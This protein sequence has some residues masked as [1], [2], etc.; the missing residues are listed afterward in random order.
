MA[1]TTACGTIIDLIPVAERVHA[2]G[3][4]LFVDA[5]QFAPHGPL[6]V[7][8]F[9][10]DLL[11]CSGYKI[12]GPH[13]G[14]MWGKKEVLDSLPAFREYFIQD[15]A[16]DKYEVGT[17]SFE[18]IAGMN[19][20][21]GYVE[22]LGRRSRHL[23]LAPEESVGRRGDM[24]R[25][26]QVIRHYERTLSDRLLGRIRELPF[27]EVFGLVEPEHA[28]LRTPT[29]CF[30]VKG[31]E[32]AKVTQSLAQEGIFVRDGHLYCPRLFRALG[33][34]EETGAVR[35]SLVHYNSVEEMDRFVDALQ[36]LSR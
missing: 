11:V 16:P 21:I 9:G 4:Y 34:S 18:G 35:A 27:I 15:R 10:C 13:I 36:G 8:F 25:G 14:F 1:S 20:A 3:G 17:Q 5:V 19:A 28:A 32:P 29:L 30:N 7:R 2:R 23:P 24:R 33:L 12:F 26:M 31:T 22:E 6:D